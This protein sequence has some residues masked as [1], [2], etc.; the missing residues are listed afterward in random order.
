[1]FFRGKV[2]Y[3]RE[4]GIVIPK[5]KIRSLQNFKG[6]NNLKIIKNLYLLFL[7]IWN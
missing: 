7:K 1:M 5:T 3:F 2:N 4:E 6:D